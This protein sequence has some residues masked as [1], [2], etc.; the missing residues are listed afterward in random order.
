MLLF[1]NIIL[2][3]YIER[4]KCGVWCVDEKRCAVFI[5]GDGNC[6]AKG[7][8]VGSQVKP[9]RVFTGCYNGLKEAHGCF[10]GDAGFDQLC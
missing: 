6:G 5:D 7:N 4:K 2:V 8:T 9:F 3:K 10:S 1:V